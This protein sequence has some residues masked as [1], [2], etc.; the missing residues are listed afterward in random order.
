MKKLFSIFIAAFL[1]FSIAGCTNTEEN[2]SNSGIETSQENSTSQKSTDNID[3]EKDGNVLVVYYSATGTTEKVAKSIA[4][5]KDADIF[6]ITPVKEYTSE[7]LDWTNENS[8]VSVEHNDLD[9]RNVELVSTKPE[10][11]NDYDTVFIGYPIW[12]GIAAWPVNNFVKENDFT[13]KTVI[14]FCT[15]SSSD[16]GESGDLLAEMASTGA[17]QQGERFNSSSEADEINSWIDSLK[18]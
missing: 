4:D 10:N 2:N 5:Y 12:W 1:I 17:W 8:R 13:G 18:Y 6:V 9:R 15:S 16:I 14:P 11:F 3:K 7:D